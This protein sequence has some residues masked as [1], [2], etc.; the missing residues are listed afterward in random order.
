MGYDEDF[1]RDIIYINRV[2][3]WCRFEEGVFGGCVGDADVL[4]VVWMG[5]QGA[6][7]E[8]GLSSLLYN[9]RST[10]GA[11]RCASVL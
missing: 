10:V 2:R 5:V 8:D 11:D 7:W 6:V 1:L 3:V 4:L 9:V